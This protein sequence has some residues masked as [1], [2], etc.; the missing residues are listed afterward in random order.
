[1]AAQDMPAQ[2]DPKG[3]V[4]PTLFL[5]LGGTGKEVLLRLRRRF[6][7]RMGV[8][9]L[10]CMAYL[11]LDTDTRD[12]LAFGERVDET[13]AAVAFQPQ[14]A[15][16]LLSGSVKDDLAQILFNRRTWPQIHSWLP[17]EVGRYG[18]E[19]ADGAGGVRAV[20]R[21][22]YFNHFA[23]TINP[24][25]TEIID[26]VRTHDRINRT[27]DFFARR[28]LTPPDILD[29]A[30]QI[31]LVSS[32]AGGTGCGTFLDA[33]FHLRHLVREYGVQVER[34]IAMLFMPNV[35]YAGS[36]G[37]VAMRSYGNA[38][39][40]LKELEYYTLRLANAQ[41]DL[42]LDFET[43]WERG[44]NQSTAGPPFNIAYL[45]EMKNEGGTPMEPENRTEVFDVVA[46]SLYLDFMPGAFSTAK[47]SHYSN[48]A[49][50]LAGVAGTNISFDNVALPQ[51]FARRYASCG[52]S[53]IEIP[54]DRI[55]AACAA[56][57]AHAVAAYINRESSDP[58]IGENVRGDMA[59]LGLDAPGF[60]KQFGSGW[61]DNIRSVVGAAIPRSGVGSI[62]K[63]DELDKQI[64]EKEAGLI[65]AE[66][67]EP[68]RWGSA[69]GMIRNGTGAVARKIDEILGQWVRDTLEN[70]ARGL[71]ILVSERQEGKAGQAETQDGY[72]RFMTEYLKDL[73]A[74]S[75][76]GATAVLDQMQ[77]KAAADAKRFSARRDGILRELRQAVRS[78]GLMLLRRADWAK[79]TL[80]ARLKEAEEQY[81]LASVEIVALDCARKAAQAAVESLAQ[82][83][84]PLQAL[85]TA[86]AT[87][88]QGFLAAYEKALSFG[89]SVLL[90]RFF[91]RAKDWPSFYKLEVNAQG[92]AMDVDPRAEYRRFLSQKFATPSGGE[93]TLWNLLELFTRKGDRE[94]RAKLRTFSEERFRVDFD[95]HPRQVDLL[96][97]PQLAQNWEDAIDRM[98]RSAMPMARREASLGGS[99]VAVE[100]RAYLGVPRLA[101]ESPQDAAF[102]EDVRN[103]LKSKVSLKPTEI[104]VHPTGKPYEVYLYI[105]VYA[106]PLPAL[107]IVTNECHKAYRDFYRALGNQS[108][109][110]AKHQIPLHL[111]SQWE[112]KFEDLKVYT[113]S[114][115]QR[116][117]EAREVL[118]F[119]GVLRVLEMA[120]DDEGRVVYSYNSGPP[121]YQTVRLGVQREA[122]GD[123]EDN[124]K[125]RAEFLQTV[126]GRERL[127]GKSLETYYWALHYMGRCGAFPKA[128]TEDT[129]LN[130][131]IDQIYQRL[132]EEKVAKESLDISAVKDPLADARAKIEGAVDWICGLPVLKEV[133]DWSARA[134]AK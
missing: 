134:V 128:T 120:P 76:P 114:E 45:M 35:F 66:G 15:I 97:H 34:I 126:V 52:M 102:T 22:T 19:I 56:H 5:G 12:N 41:T 40:A 82:R 4:R 92:Q 25:L 133:S 104:S 2:P 123:L 54:V 60:L 14:E 90:I 88:S 26:S 6:Y 38:Y 129:L 100:K 111:S 83:R 108:I 51:S 59:R 3:A 95:S 28:E 42:S 101:I 37:E 8:V 99:P 86:M 13:F 116:I 119:G 93:P 55:K 68:V 73:Y 130:Q 67:D 63:V 57:L 107:K 80:L 112:G 64:R 69:V 103:K 125:L 47:R 36:S 62:E 31:V 46:E 94:V 7:E 44:S 9:G 121:R 27:R 61:K 127:L 39:A 98:V 29:G 74:A 17:P 115:A 72:L 96:S 71:K 79:D 48:V 91:D 65:A 85:S 16:S 32:L 131:R 53:K 18:A 77:A 58:R 20:G 132:L 24:A 106:F 118:L 1:M 75:R 78:K 23:D 89:E 81:C 49:G 117:K 113:E 21:L 124:D 87:L 110:E 10:P 109:T 70:D 11:W 43:E 33:A 105:V 50:S 30:T 122:V 84:P